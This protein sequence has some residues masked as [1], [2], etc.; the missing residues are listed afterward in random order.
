MTHV[1]LV[2][3][4]GLGLEDLEMVLELVHQSNQPGALLAL[5]FLAR[6]RR[7]LAIAALLA[8]TTAIMPSCLFSF[9]RAPLSSATPT[10]LGPSQHTCVCCSAL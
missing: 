7:S 10:S 3:L 4:V 8:R 1:V 2:S 9:S 6:L 5:G